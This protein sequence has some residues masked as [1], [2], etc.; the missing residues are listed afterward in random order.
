MSCSSKGLWAVFCLGFALFASLFAWWMSLPPSPLPPNA[1]ETEFSAARALKHTEVIS[2]VPHPA[3][4]VANDAVCQYIQDQVKALGLEMELI[5]EPFG[6][7]HNITWSRAVLARLR[8]TA[9]TKAFAVDAHF[10]SVPYGPG[11]SDDDSGIATMLET[12]RALKA[13]PPL[14]NDVIFAFTDQEETGGDGARAFIN[15][16]WFKNVGVMLGLEVRGTKGPSLMFETS[17]EN[18]WLIRELA[19]AGVHPRTTSIMFDIYDRLPFG[20]NFGQYKHHVPGYNIAFI[21]NFCYYHTRLDNP[22]NLNMASLQHHGEYT[23]N[24]AKHLGNIP[25]D[26]CRAPNA[27]YFN[28]F[29][30]YLVVYPQSWSLPLTCVA[31]AMFA[32]A[33][34]FSW[35]RGRLRIGG[36]VA[37][38]VTIL[39]AVLLAL[40]AWLPIAA[41][42]YWRFREA[43]LYQNNA[44]C[45]SFV[46]FALCTL[47]LLVGAF[48]NKIR[49]VEWLAGS[50]FWWA[51]LLVLLQQYLVGGTYAAVWPLMLGAVALVAL[52]FAK[53]E[54]GGPSPH[55]MA[56]TT[57][58]ILP[59]LLIVAPT[60]FMFAY[61]LTILGG[62]LLIPLTVVL[63]SQL[64]PHIASIPL[65]LRWKLP[66]VLCIAS[67]V[68]CVGAFFANLPRAECPKL[69]CL[70]YG[71]DFDKNQ[72]YWLS[73]D[74]ETDEWTAQF[75]PAGTT[76]AKINEFISHDEREYFKAPAPAAPFGKPVMAVVADRI[77]NGRRI[78]DMHIDSTRDS[79]YFNLRVTSDA[80]VYAAHAAGI[81]LKSDKNHWNARFE[82][83]PR[84]GIDLHIETDP[85]A[86]LIFEVNEKSYGVPEFP[87][88]QPRPDWM[89]TEPN[90]T[91]DHRRPLRSEHTFS[92]CTIDLGSGPEKS[93]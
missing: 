56:L 21:D 47:F 60:L 73:A 19:K 16:P 2:Q 28:L 80:P 12:A 48:R 35:I 31:L 43:S 8:G 6:G 55:L 92:T 3:G 30:D 33:L 53:E 75:F 91:L 22:E 84:P 51:I 41:S 69:N 61:T 40:L 74:A 44:Y 68:V 67:I 45:V 15:H 29:G 13:G 65:G 18:G 50:L 38:W 52:S 89:A 1:P 24:L 58:L 59:S 87:G 62:C 70:S 23:L 17:Q 54:Q 32:A 10:D 63:S 76:R 36:F 11:A 39:V 27:N 88:F 72:G 78:L 4:S 9:S 25:L 57:A 46:I 34:G 5:Y 49:P 83:M 93:S 20:S 37:A 71:M 64:A 79:L 85:G 14:K 82:M 66:L 26:Q 86:P 77:E 81:D 42:L 90:R 7:G